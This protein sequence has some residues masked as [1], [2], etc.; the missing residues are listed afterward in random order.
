MAAVAGLLTLNGYEP[1]GLEK[2]QAIRHV[3]REAHGLPLPW[4]SAA[5]GTCDGSMR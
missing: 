2:F 5:K 4:K 1:A 3:G